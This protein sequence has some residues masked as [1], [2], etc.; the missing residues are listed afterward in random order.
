MTR[1]S[2]LKL[3]LVVLTL[4]AASHAHHSF[5]MFDQSKTVTIAG[6]FKKAELTNPH[7]WYWVAEALPNGETKLWG[8]EG[9]GTSQVRTDGMSLKDYFTPGQKVSMTMHPLRDGRAGG[10]LVSIRFADGRL[11]GSTPTRLP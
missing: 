6:T 3:I 1:N 10:Q 9:G 7:T 5:A 4:G 2:G 8:A 11:F